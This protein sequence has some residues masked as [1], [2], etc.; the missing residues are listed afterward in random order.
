MN[1]I[2]A[3]V[4]VGLATFYLS[5]KCQS[6]QQQPTT[7]SNISLQKTQFGTSLGV[8]IESDVNGGGY[9][10]GSTSVN[11]FAAN[12]GLEDAILSKISA[13]GTTVWSKQYGSSNNDSFT[14]ISRCPSGDIIIAGY[15]DGDLFGASG[16]TRT[17]FL[18]RMNS[19]GVLQSTKLI[20]SIVEDIAVID[21]S[22]TRIL[23]EVR[24][25]TADDFDS[26]L[27][28]YD[29]TWN[30]VATSNEQTPPKE[31]EFIAHDA[32]QYQFFVD[33][34][35]IVNYNENLQ[36]INELMI[37]NNDPMDVIEVDGHYY[38]IGTV[39]QSDTTD[40]VATSASNGISTTLLS[41]PN[42]VNDYSFRVEA[43][44]CSGSKARFIVSAEGAEYNPDVEP[45]NDKQ[46]QKY[47][48]VY[49]TDV[50]TSTTKLFDVYTA[51]SVITPYADVIKRTDGS[52]LCTTCWN[53]FSFGG[54]AP[55][56]TLI[57]VYSSNGT[58]LGWYT[59][60]EY[61]ESA[62]VM[63]TFMFGS[64]I[65]MSNDEQNY[66]IATLPTVAAP[67]FS[68]APGTYTGTQSVSISCATT[69]AVIRYTTDGS[70]PTQ[71]SKRYS[72]PLSISTNTTVKARAF[73]TATLPSLRSDAAY[74][75]RRA[76]ASKQSK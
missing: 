55:V 8:C 44:D 37:P 61:T 45:M 23:V 53:D 28:L 63:G 18:L 34:N 20:S 19:S 12:Q 68:L 48:S 56:G 4:L 57:G 74:K 10:Y 6:V 52:Y 71:K 36:V 75:L 38:V 60:P 11:T 40:I 32:L 26:H 66:Y 76:T 17:W 62:Y 16:T 54:L 31:Y 43:S 14:S 24:T 9:A 59:L 41:L 22:N 7:L 67:S 64:Q 30:L 13:N 15:T 3:S 33:S 46:Y 1:I 65:N 50:T 70:E 21:T 5:A 58:M 35:K 49:E 27:E 39:Y 72:K 69:G 73:K 2:L 29:N 25:S 47:A 51:P 42:T